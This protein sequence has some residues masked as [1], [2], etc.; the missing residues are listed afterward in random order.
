MRPRKGRLAAAGYY[1]YYEVR[2]HVASMVGARRG[3]GNGAARWGC[4]V[5][6][7]AAR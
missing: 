4:E 2:V 3:A 1:Y 5:E 6:E 7:G